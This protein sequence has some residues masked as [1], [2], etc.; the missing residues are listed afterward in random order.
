MYN[1]HIPTGE[2]ENEKIFN[3]RITIRNRSIIGRLHFT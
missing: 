3:Q 2:V 1:R